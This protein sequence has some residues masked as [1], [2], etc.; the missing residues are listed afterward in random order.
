MQAKVAERF[1]WASHGLESLHV[2][3]LV[4]H[5]LNDYSQIQWMLD[6]QAAD[7]SFNNNLFDTAAAIIYLPLGVAEK[8]SAKHYLSSM[9]DN[10]GSWQQDPLLTGFCLRALNEN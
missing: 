10:M 2:S 4:A 3:A 7:G 9:Q 6:Q 8:N 5:A 1:G